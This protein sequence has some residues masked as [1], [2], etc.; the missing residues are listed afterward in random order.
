[1]SKR[2]EKAIL[3]LLAQAGDTKIMYKILGNYVFEE[4]QWATHRSEFA[5]RNA[6][7]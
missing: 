3:T 2:S 4:A 1:M 7:T 6:P 5:I